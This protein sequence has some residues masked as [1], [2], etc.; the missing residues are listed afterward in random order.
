[1]KIFLGSNYI[2]CVAQGK[3]K[4][5]KRGIFVP[6]SNRFAVFPQTYP[7]ELEAAVGEAR[8]NLPLR[9]R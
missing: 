9:G 7:V 5:K 1:M 4:T 8:E 3:D 6:L 2:M